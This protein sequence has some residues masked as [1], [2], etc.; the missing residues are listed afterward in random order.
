[1][2]N[3]FTLSLTF[4]FVLILGIGDISAQRTCATLLHAQQLG[5]KNPKWYANYLN[6]ENM[7]SE[8]I[9]KH[10]AT[11]TSLSST[12]YTIPVVVHVLY[13]D[14]SENIPDSQIISQ[15]AVL[16]EDFGR[17]NADTVNT[18]AG[19]NVAASTGFQFCLAQRDPDD[20][21]TTGIDRFQTT[22]FQFDMALDDVKYSAVGGVDAWDSDKYLNIWV[23]DLDPAVL[24]YGEAPDVIHTASYGVVI[25][26]RNFGRGGSTVAPF[27][28]G[29]TTT[30]EIGH[31]FD[32]DHIWGDGSGC[33]VDDN[34][35]DTPP[36]DVETIGCLSFPAFDACTPSGNG[37]MF[38][39]YMDYSDDSCMNMFTLGQ[40]GRM[41]FS[42]SLLYPSLLSSSGCQPVVLTN[43]DVWLRKIVEPI[44]Q[45]C[46]PNISPMIRIKNY[47]NSQIDSVTINYAFNGGSFSSFQWVGSLASLANVDISLP[48]T[49][50]SA[51]IH[52][53]TVFTSNPNSLADPV[54]INDTLTTSFEIIGNGVA[55]PYTEGFEGLTFPPLNWT[56][57]N[58][59]NDYTWEQ[60]TLAAKTDSTSIFVNNYFYDHASIPGADPNDDIDLPIVDL[61]SVTNPALKFDVAYTYYEGQFVTSTD[62]LEVWISADCGSNFTRLYQ[63]GGVDLSTAPDTVIEFIPDSSQWRSETIG[64]GAY[65][66]ATQVVF[67]FRNINGFGNNLYIDNINLTSVTSLDNIL[68]SSL[69]K[70]FPNPSTGE[71]TLDLQKV[72]NEIY[73]LS[74]F[75]ALGK[76]VYQNELNGQTSR[77]QLNLSHL[78]AGIYYARLFSDGEVQMISLVINN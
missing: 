70:V 3:T 43:N 27:N 60:T 66:S 69:V 44:G 57:L 68:N 61:S 33:L 23:C 45:T 6:R 72:K 51:G 55:L 13:D 21:P 78:D 35:S 19:F 50:L 9:K 59:D 28:L 56:I 25:N 36:Q 26:Y 16:N 20:N 46:D 5:A 75:D 10:P 53:L 11:N 22:V 77:H 18:P 74:V 4:F 65:A 76:T 42:M 39:N 1:M 12:V 63:K 31:C 71:F 58:P 7:I 15:I 14:P 41:Q 29:R 47:G 30:H 2:K 54:N 62:T 48:P 38:M 8:W 24:G 32:L 73:Q 64:L 34:I 67:R 37:I 17:M 49:T 40:G 52:T